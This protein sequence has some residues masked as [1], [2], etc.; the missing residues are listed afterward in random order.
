M[1]LYISPEPT[2]MASALR[3]LTGALC[4]R[5]FQTFALPKSP[6]SQ[7]HLSSCLSNNAISS[8]SAAR[9]FS[10]CFGQIRTSQ[11]FQPF[12]ASH[13]FQ[14]TKHI[15]VTLTQVRNYKVRAVLKRR[16]KSC[17]FVKRQN[18]MFVE[19][20][21]KPRHKQ[22]Q[23]M[24]KRNLWREDYSKGNIVKA[25]FWKLNEKRYYKM[26]DNKFAR[27]DWLKGKIGVTIWIRLSGH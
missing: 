8:V 24:S 17:Y 5:I 12:A 14:M 4:S 10:S 27:H 6:N 2:W 20:K 1:F 23:M 15:P 13:L 25:I 3:Q 19:C 7:T 21:A 22:M 9:F 11:L 16:C 18:R 26:G